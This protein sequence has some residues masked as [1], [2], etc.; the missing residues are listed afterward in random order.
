MHLIN[1]DGDIFSLAG[2]YG[3][4]FDPVN[5]RNLK[6]FLLLVAPPYA[7]LPYLCNIQRLP[8]VLKDPQAWLNEGNLGVIQDLNV[9]FLDVKKTE[10][11]IRAVQTP[12]ADIDPHKKAS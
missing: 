1:L 2:V 8:I 12:G 6:F 7:P 4:F 9:E 5:E 10:S 11:L 3:E